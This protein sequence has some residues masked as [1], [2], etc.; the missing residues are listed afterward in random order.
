MQVDEVEKFFKLCM[1]Y[2][3][4]KITYTFLLAQLQPYEVFIVLLPSISHTEF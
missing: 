1:C 4:L 3:Y 2:I